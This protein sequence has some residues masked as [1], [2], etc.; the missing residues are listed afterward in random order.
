[1]QVF[2]VSKDCNPEEV[3]RTIWNNFDAAIKG[4]DADAESIRASI[5]LIACGGDGT[6]AWVLNSVRCLP[7]YVRQIPSLHCLIIPRGHVWDR[8][9]PPRPLVNI[10]VGEH[11]PCGLP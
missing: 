8:L 3:L 11:L 4:G 6:I 7:L 9:K 1:L 5:R 10:L 2:E